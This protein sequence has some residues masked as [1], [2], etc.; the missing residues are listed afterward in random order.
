MAN[1]MY[2]ISITSSIR[3]GVY[4]VS[5]MRLLCLLSL[6]VL[7]GYGSD[8]LGHVAVKQCGIREVTDEYV[9]ES[10]ERLPNIV[11]QVKKPSPYL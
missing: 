7:T 8:E 6:S 11:T 1:N 2:F 5:C 4:G 9:I 3:R 10:G